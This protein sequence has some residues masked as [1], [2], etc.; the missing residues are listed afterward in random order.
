[1]SILKLLVLFGS[2][3]LVAGIYIGFCLAS[4]L[5]PITKKRYY[6]QGR[7]DEQLGINS[8]DKD[9]IDPRIMTVKEGYLK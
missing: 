7:A 4:W 5:D 2:V 9:R 1:M 8:L 3:V 6:L